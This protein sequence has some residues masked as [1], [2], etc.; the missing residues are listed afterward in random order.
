MPWERGALKLRVRPSTRERREEEWAR[1]LR[2]QSAVRW[3]MGPV[4]RVRCAAWIAPL[5]RS[6]LGW[7]AALVWLWPELV[8]ALPESVVPMLLPRGR[9]VPRVGPAAGCPWV[10]Q[11]ERPLGQPRERPLPRGLPAVRMGLIRFHRREAPGAPRARPPDRLA[12]VSSPASDKRCRLVAIPQ[13]WADARAGN[14]GASSG[15]GRRLRSSGT[16]TILPIGS[17]PCSGSKTQGVALLPLS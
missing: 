8:E 14:A 15:P 12:R 4:W 3:A 1:A 9:P 16:R 6:S 13:A 2:R 11:P 17:A 10:Q 5:S 7:D